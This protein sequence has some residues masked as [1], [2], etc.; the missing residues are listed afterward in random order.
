MSVYS[1]YF[2]PTGGT[3]RVMDI[4]TEGL[5][6]DSKIDLSESKTDYSA[7]NFTEADVC[8]IGV[9]SF[10][11]R[12]PA[13]VLERMRKMQANG[14]MM[15][16]VVVFGNRAYDDTLLELKNEASACGY[17]VGAAVAAVAEHSIMRQYGKERPDAQDEMEL[18][19]FSKE[20]AELIT[21][22]K[23]INDFTVPGNS[24]YREY[25][26]VPFKP[27]A[28]KACTKCGLCAEKC[29]VQAIPKDNPMSLEEKKC[30]SC[31]RCIAVCP[32]N[33][34]KLNKAVLLAASQAMKKAFVDRK[35]NE[36][37]LANGKRSY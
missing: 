6:I 31:M 10:G 9:P 36:F 5:S 20:I 18:R 33:A 15:V 35:Q 22:K 23:T 3:K 8:L 2:S 16:L 11:G 12:V 17:T 37:Y 32:Q 24:P 1:M 4:L 13:I 14:A 29:P 26:G 25:S 28:D 34:R 21:S 30:I 7:Y 27:K 19:Q